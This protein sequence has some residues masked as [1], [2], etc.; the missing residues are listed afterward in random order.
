M[1]E[2]SCWKM[3]RIDSVPFNYGSVFCR[4]IL[5][6]HSLTWRYG[7]FGAYIS[8]SINYGVYWL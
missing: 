7:E 6:F 8:R 5:F 4:G 1:R 3:G 2:C